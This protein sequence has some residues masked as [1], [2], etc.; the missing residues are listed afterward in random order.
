M[1]VLL[2][3][4]FITIFISA[5]C[6]L[7]EATLYS[8]RTGALEAAKLNSNLQ[9]RAQ[10]MIALKQN[11]SAPISAILILNTIANTAGATLAGMYAHTVL[12]TAMVPL[13]SILFTLAILFVAEIMPKTIGAVYWRGLW[14]FIVWPIM[15][16][17]SVMNPFLFVT[18][19]FTGLLTPK[20]TSV[21]FVT[22]EEILGVIRMGA[23]EGEISQLESQMVHNII[24]L[25]DR[26]IS[27]IMTPRTVVFS[28]AETLSV[29]EA[30]KI[31]CKKGFTRIPVYRDDRENVTGYV[32]MPDL[33]SEKIMRDPSKTLTDISKPVT[34]VSEE[35][36]CLAMLTVFLK[37]RR[38]I[39]IVNDE[40][41]GVAGLVTLEDLLET[42]LGAEIVDETDKDI[43][44]QKVA[45][46]RNKRS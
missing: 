34:F 36:D 45:L 44:M 23:R 8:T 21:P 19:K 16:M 9:G 24:S 6:S 33:G 32:M 42:V 4:V 15:F 31:A 17:K 7:Y 30:Y 20:G 12:G 41:G 27:E 2:L 10:K 25:E 22:E 14:P 43:D 29:K 1:F 5:Q 40:Y 39:A 3:V 38:H 26:K 18:Q 35:E 37:K 13:F 11:V 28:L 46:K